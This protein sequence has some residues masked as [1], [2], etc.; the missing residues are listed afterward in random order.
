M[1]TLDTIDRRL[2]ALLQQDAT[3]SVNS[4]AER[5]NLSTT[6][7][8]K[9]LKRL[10]EQGIITGKVAIIDRHKVQLA[11]S[12]FVHIKTQHHDND[13]LK[14]FSETVSRYDEVMECYRMAGEWDYLLRVV[15][16]DIP[17]FDRFYKRLVTQVPGIVNVTSNFAM[18]EIKYTTSLPIG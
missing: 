15:V 3:L 14:H 9:R 4:L 1:I 13:W 16:A 11:V 12:V 17:A 2:I 7:C 10:E 8:W 18:E 6:P 5:V